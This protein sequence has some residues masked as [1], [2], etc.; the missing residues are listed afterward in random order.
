[1]TERE[2]V[3]QMALYI[4][5]GLLVVLGNTNAFESLRLAVFA[6]SHHILQE[7]N[8]STKL[9]LHICVTE[10]HWCLHTPLC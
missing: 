2:A 9:F 8:S 1:M 7:F 10:L 4:P 6:E 5:E 3:H